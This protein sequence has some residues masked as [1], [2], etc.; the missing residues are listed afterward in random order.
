VT[1]PV[2]LTILAAVVVAAGL[3]WLELHPASRSG[4]K[5]RA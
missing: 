3:P 4:T 2:T 5:R 1:V